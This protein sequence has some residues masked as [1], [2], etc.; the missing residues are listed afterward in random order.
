MAETRWTPG[1]WHADR[2]FDICGEDGHV[3]ADCF[4]KPANARLMAAAPELY[5][6]LAK[7]VPRFERACAHAGSDEEFIAEATATARAALAKARGDG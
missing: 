4:G 7:L 1:P 5:E 2:E 3:I 6:A